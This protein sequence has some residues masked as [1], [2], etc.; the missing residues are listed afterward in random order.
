MKLYKIFCV[1]KMST[2]AE[3]LS[4]CA[5]KEKRFIT[6]FEN[7]SMNLQKF[8]SYDT[9]GHLNEVFDAIISRISNYIPSNDDEYKEIFIKMNWNETF[10]TVCVHMTLNIPFWNILIHNHTLDYMVCELFNKKLNNIGFQLLTI[11]E[12][13]QG[14]DG[15]G[16]PDCMIFTLKLLH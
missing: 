7:W 6:F 16:G 8:H 2:I 1:F 14:N 10:D 3:S 9:I 5:K 15:V 13:D 11:P 12:V 4:N